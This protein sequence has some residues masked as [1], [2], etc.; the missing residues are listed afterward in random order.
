[1]SRESPAI[2]VEE[3][4]QEIDL[5]NQK[6]TSYGQNLTSYTVFSDF[7]SICCHISTVYVMLKLFRAYNRYPSR[8]KEIK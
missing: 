5:Y 6:R 2:H 4:F 7:S 1:M 3:A 8:N